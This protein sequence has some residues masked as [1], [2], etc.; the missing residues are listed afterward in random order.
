MSN[1]ETVC[2]CLARDA[3]QHEPAAYR[4]TGI[5]TGGGTLWGIY[6]E[7]PAHPGERF[8]SPVWT[9]RYGRLSNEETGSACPLAVS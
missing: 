5:A 3:T 1:F 2:L 9:Q 6:P 7:C 8:T 4:W